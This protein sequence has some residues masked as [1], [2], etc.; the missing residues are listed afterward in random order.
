MSTN[1]PTVVPTDKHNRSFHYCREVQSGVEI[2]L[3]PN[4]TT[5]KNYMNFQFMK[6]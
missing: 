2:S 6:F 4:Q 5:K 3:L 1:R